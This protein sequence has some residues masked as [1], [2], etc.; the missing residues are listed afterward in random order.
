MYKKIESK[1]DNAIFEARTD[2]N[3]EIM[4]YRIAPAEGYKLHEI[5]LDEPVVDEKTGIETG[6]ITKGYT[7]AFV[8]A[9]MNYDFEKNPREIYAER[10]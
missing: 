3:G 6:E 10:E 4:S 5:T 8:T 7:K 2:L 9:G 1:L